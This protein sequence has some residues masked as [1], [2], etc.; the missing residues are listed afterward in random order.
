M[1]VDWIF[2][3][4]A[5]LAGI[6]VWTLA[7][8]RSRLAVPL[9]EAWARQEGY[10]L[11]RARRAWVWLGPF[12]AGTGNSQSVFRLTVVSG[13]V[14]RSGWARVGGKWD[15][16]GASDEVEVLLDPPLTTD[17]R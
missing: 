3:I 1:G 15:L 13:G 4:A 12:T 2:L 14:R 5:G 7:V 17:H 9:L 11:I 6:A 16:L 10:E 8:R